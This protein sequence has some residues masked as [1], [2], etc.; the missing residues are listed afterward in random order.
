MMKILAI[1]GALRKDSWNTQLLRAVKE[2]APPEMAIE[3]VTL[4]GV[5]LYDGDEEDK[6]GVPTSVKALQEKVRE[7]D[8]VIISTPEYNFSVP[9][10]LKNGLDWMSRS[11]NPFKWKRVGVMGASEGPIGTGR[12]QYHLRQNLVGLEAITMPKPEIFVA[13]A[14]KKFAHGKL[15]DETTKKIIVTWL[16]AFKDWVKRG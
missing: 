16:A 3:I 10:V 5:P 7:A 1:T 6:H 4:H 15:T 14:D 9:G 11:G 13:L 12:S 8:G 2:L